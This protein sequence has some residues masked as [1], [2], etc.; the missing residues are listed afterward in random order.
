MGTKHPRVAPAA[1]MCVRVASGLRVPMDAWQEGLQKIHLPI[2]PLTRTFVTHLLWCTCYKD[3][4]RYKNTL[5]PT[6]RC[7]YPSIEHFHDQSKKY[8]PQGPQ[9]ECVRTHAFLTKVS[10]NSNLYYS[11]VLASGLVSPFGT[12]KLTSQPAGALKE[13]ALAETP[14]KQQRS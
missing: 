3:V 12:T 8:A 14:Q 13:I 1:V 4:K 2:H 6:L 11:D 10:Q 5:V 7:L 9:L